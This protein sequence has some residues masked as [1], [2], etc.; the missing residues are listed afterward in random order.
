MAEGAPLLREYGG[1]LIE[2]SNPFLSASL[3]KIC[4]PHTIYVNCSILSRDVIFI[5]LSKFVIY[6]T[7][8]LIR[9]LVISQRN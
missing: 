4:S 6:F 5:Y 8:L 7:L 2:G 3:S 1:N 9:M